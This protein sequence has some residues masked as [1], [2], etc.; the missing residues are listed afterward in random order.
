MVIRIIT[1][2]TGEQIQIIIIAPVNLFYIFSF[3]QNWSLFDYHLYQQKSMKYLILN[4]DKKKKMKNGYWNIYIIQ[5][6]SSTLALYFSRFFASR[7]YYIVVDERRRLSWLPYFFTSQLRKNSIRF[8]SSFTTFQYYYFFRSNSYSALAHWP[9]E[10][11]STPPGGAF[12]FTFFSISAQKNKKPVPYTNISVVKMAKSFY[13]STGKMGQA[14][15][16]RGASFFLYS[17]K[18]NINTVTLENG[19]GCQ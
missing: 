14:T 12:F 5:T 17:V 9:R 11:M 19:R 10:R 13:S 2:P 16:F 3:L 4:R 18:K 6:A 7:A 1:I 15:P 8:T